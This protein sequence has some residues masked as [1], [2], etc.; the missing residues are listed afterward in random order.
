MCQR[1]QRPNYSFIHSMRRQYLA[2]QKGLKKGNLP[3][4]P[5]AGGKSSKPPP[6][7]TITW[8]IY[9][10]VSCCISFYAGV[11]LAW[12][13]SP[14]DC[15]EVQRLRVPNRSDHPPPPDCTEICLNAVIGGKGDLAQKLHGKLDVI[16]EKK[17]EKAMENCPSNRG[18]NGDSNHSTNKRFPESLSHFAKGLI[19][20]NRKDLFDQHD[21]GVPM[22]S[23]ADSQ[24]VLMLYN[25]NDA[26]PSDAQVAT[27]AK[28]RGEIPH[29]DAAS[30]TANCD[31]MNVMFV[32]PPNQLS[33]QCVAIVGGQ[34]Q[35]YHLQRWIRVVVN[36]ILDTKMDI[37]RT[38]MTKANG[39]DGMHYPTS[40]H[41]SMHRDIMLKYVT[42]Y[43][44]VQ[45][46]LGSILKKIAIDNSVIVT[47]VN[48]GQSE[49][50]INFICSSRSRGLDLSNLVV[51]PTD[52]FSKD[53]AEGMGIATFYADK[54]M[55]SIPE[56]E[57]ERYGDSTFGLI[58]MA[59][60]LCVHLVSDLGYDMLF[61]DVDVIWYKDPFKFFHDTESPIANFDVYFQDDGNRQERFAPYSANSGF[62]YIRNNQRTKLLFRNM[63]YSGDLIFA[64]R[65]HQQV[66]IS[67]LAEAN[68]LSGLRVKVLSRDGDDFPSGFHYH[69]RKDYM[70][71]FVR[72]DIDPYILHMCWTLNKDDKLKFMRQMD[73]WYVNDSCIGK[74]ST[75]ILSGERVGGDI[76]GACCSAEPLFSC[77]Y[78]DKASMRSCADSPP[79]DKNGKSFW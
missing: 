16:L 6:R 38:R 18:G 73:M 4:L 69:M 50:L 34:Y 42:S 45:S 62:Y 64:C 25:S 71:Q 66:L 63:L 68:S 52:K 70:K 59:K 33:R 65:S 35:G 7:D 49:L 1:E 41:L 46:E 2:P 3:L 77:H 17:I 15:N 21:F 24:D 22:N 55:S 75:E 26:L 78:R 53:L 10:M 40:N 12:T 57:A 13:S 28:Y 8:L 60:V 72:G 39:Y 37:L 43:N 76:V 32:N 74:E 48:K 36:L 23:N 67:L 56:E 29:T 11:W 31:S 54:L 61:Q 14:Q 9:L 79:K 27:A 19:S 47:T 44:D 30:A 51:F 58:M 5:P 20:V